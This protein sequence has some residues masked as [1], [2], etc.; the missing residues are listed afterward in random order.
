MSVSRST[1][2]RSCELRGLLLGERVD[3]HGAGALLVV[4]L[5]RQ[6]ALLAQLVQRV[7]AAGGV[8]QVGGDLG[9]EDEVGRDVAE[10]LGVVG[11][12]GAVLAAATSSAGS[13]HSPASAWLPPA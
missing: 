5:D 13:S 12:D 3:E 7:A 11:D 4:G 10:R 2:P 8:E 6:A 1:S 9:V